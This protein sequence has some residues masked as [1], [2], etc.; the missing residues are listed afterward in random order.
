MTSYTPLQIETYRGNV[1]ARDFS[2]PSSAPNISFGGIIN[3]AANN[4]ILL[5]HKVRLGS[6]SS[7]QNI[8]M[9]SYDEANYP[10][11]GGSNGINRV[12]GGGASSAL[13]RSSSSSPTLPAAGK[14]D[15]ER[16]FVAA[17]VMDTLDYTETPIIIPPGSSLWFSTSA[18]NN[19]LR[20]C[21]IWREKSS[22]A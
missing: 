15:L 17:G 16:Y 3:P 12:L 2:E 19:P 8:T 10:L 6:L 4:K 20:C 9:H 14:V 22:V 5:V 13:V 1:Y 7:G 21:F 11:S 18:V